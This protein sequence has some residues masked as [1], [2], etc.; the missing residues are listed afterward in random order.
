MNS[1]NCY[2]WLGAVQSWARHLTGGVTPWYPLERPLPGTNETVALF[3]YHFTAGRVVLRRIHAI[4]TTTIISADQFNTVIRTNMSHGHQHIGVVHHQQIVF[5]V[6]I[7]LQ[8]GRLLC[9]IGFID[10][11]NFW[12]DWRMLTTFYMWPIGPSSSKLSIET[13]V[14]GDVECYEQS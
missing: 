8:A 5:T 3:H 12:S 13:K 7:S 2:V 14:M 1:D 4:I 11:D 10:K 6:P 9:H